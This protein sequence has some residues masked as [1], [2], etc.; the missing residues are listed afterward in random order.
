MEEKQGGETYMKVLVSAASKHGA[1]S[2]ISEEIGRGLRE[3]LNERGGDEVS[4]DVRP[5]EQVSSVDDYDAVVLGSAVYAGHWLQSARELAERHAETLSERPT[6]IFSVGP[7]GDPPKP[8]EDPV[9]VASVLEA[10]RAR[11]H[12]IFAGKLDKSRLGFAEKAIVLALRAPEGDFRDWDAV[13]DWTREIAR[14][15]AP[16]SEGDA[17]RGEARA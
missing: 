1:T 12:R 3:T 15:L 9:D 7:I 10:T 11:D 2:E 17:P 14:E 5:A 16:E 4:V 6:W 13:G 8:E